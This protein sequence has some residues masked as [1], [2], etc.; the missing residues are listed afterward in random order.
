MNENRLTNNLMQRLDESYVLKTLVLG[1]CVILCIV[2]KQHEASV[3]FKKNA[4]LKTLTKKATKEIKAS[5]H[6]AYSLTA[7]FHRP[8]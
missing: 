2:L 8:L 1:Y 5:V 7:C 6:P 3:L 4:I